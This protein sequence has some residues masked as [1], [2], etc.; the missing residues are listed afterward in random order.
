MFQRILRKYEKKKIVKKKI[1]GGLA[2]HKP[3]RM[4]YLQASHAFGLNHLAS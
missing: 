4:L 2:H 3:D 1:S